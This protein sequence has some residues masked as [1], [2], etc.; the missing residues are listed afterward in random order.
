M[1]LNPLGQVPCHPVGTRMRQCAAA[2]L[3]SHPHPNLMPSTLSSAQIRLSDYT[4]TVSPRAVCIHLTRH[5]VPQSQGPAACRDLHAWVRYNGIANNAVRSA[6]KAAGVRVTS[7]EHWN[8]LWGKAMKPS[9][10]HKLHE[11]QRV[12]LKLVASSVQGLRPACPAA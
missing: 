5:M 11:Q 6:F 2:E 3:P 1:V 12:S 10:Y 9:G 8:V 4:A 7:R